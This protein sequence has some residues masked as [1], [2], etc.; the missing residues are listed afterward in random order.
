MIERDAVLGG[1]AGHIAGRL[2]LELP[3]LRVCEGFAGRFSAEELR[4]KGSRVPAVYVS[5]LSAKRRDRQSGGFARHDLSMAAY[6][7][8]G[9]VQ[10]R[11]RDAD[12]LVICQRL[13]TLV[14]NHDWG[15]GDLGVQQGEE[16]AL[17]S[18][19]TAAVRNAATSLWAVT[20]TQPFIIDPCV[21]AST[22]VPATLYVGGGLRGENGPPHL[23]VSGAAT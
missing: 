11:D 7:V 17:Q 3:A 10:G 23:P 21:T 1:L 16:P 22:P 13:L 9:P 8:T 15:L 18:L 14:D 20:W 4:A 2:I 5:L 12:A 19:V 6:V